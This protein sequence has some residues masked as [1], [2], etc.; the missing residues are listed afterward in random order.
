MIKKKSGDLAAESAVTAQ[1][2]ELINK[3]SRKTLTADDVYTFSVVLCDNEIDRDCEYFTSQSLEQLAQLFVGVTGI[4]D[5]DPT[6]KNQVAR[7]Y[8][9]RVENLAPQKTRYGEDYRRLVAKAYVPI[10][11]GTTDLIAMLDAGIQ[12]EVSVGCRIESCT[13]SICG[14]DMRSSGCCHEKGKYYGEELCCGILS[15]PSDAY[16][17]SF[18]AVPAQKN[19]GVIKSFSDILLESESGGETAQRVLSKSA[20][21]GGC[22]TV[23]KAEAEK[24]KSY[25]DSLKEKSAQADKLK[26]MMELETVKS[27]VT[28]KSEIDSDLLEVMVKNLSFE[29]LMK[30]KSVFEKKA[31]SIFPVHSQIA[32]AENSKNI[33]R[34]KNSQYSI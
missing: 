14:E 21:S 13:C 9:C 26:S 2:L 30:L 32:P 25:I 31:E 34:E 16:E 5:H 18:T 28:A 23:S 12:K 7:I 17:W 3:Y 8:Q 6:A 29:Q 24:I 4:Y 27:A 15:Q 11:D 1:E 33:R 10:C 19:A 22:V 20:N